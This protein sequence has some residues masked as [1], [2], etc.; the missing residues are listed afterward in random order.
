MEVDKKKKCPTGFEIIGKGYFW[1]LKEGCNCNTKT[2]KAMSTGSCDSK[3]TKLGCTDIPDI[4]SYWMSVVNGKKYCGKREANL[5]LLNMKKPKKKQAKDK[6]SC[7][8][9]D[10]KVCGSPKASEKEENVFCIPKAQK[11]PL[12]SITFDNKGKIKGS[13]DAKNGMAIISL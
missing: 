8:S 5:N 9:K 6:Y 12:T 10:E 7:Q 4:A 3:Q 1:G 13:Q 11:C 2:R